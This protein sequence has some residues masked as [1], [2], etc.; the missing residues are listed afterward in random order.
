[1]NGEIAGRSWQPG[2]DVLPFRKNPGHALD[3]KSFTRTPWQMCIECIAVLPDGVNV[4]P[5]IN[6]LPTSRCG[7]WR[8][9]SGLRPGK[10]AWKRESD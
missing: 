10:A 6:P 9:G 8:T 5:G 4:L 7:C 3:E 1:M 2:C